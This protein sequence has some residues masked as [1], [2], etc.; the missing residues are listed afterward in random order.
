L[1]RTLQERHLR[2]IGSLRSARQWTA[3]LVKNLLE[4]THGF[5]TTR[6][7]KVHE[8]AANGLLLA[9]AAALEIRI[10]EVYAL[11]IDGLAAFDHWYIEKGLENILQLPGYDQLTWL[12]GILETRHEYSEHMDHD[13]EQMRA[14]MMDFLIP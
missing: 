6:N 4:L 7:D 12:D 8:R 10:R 1:W 14:T 5:W 2:D 13:T 3:G 9:E 11:G